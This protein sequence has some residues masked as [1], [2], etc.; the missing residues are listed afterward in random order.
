MTGDS[1]R[2]APAGASAPGR[3]PAWPWRRADKGQLAAVL[4]AG[5]VAGLYGIVAAVA[6]AS[7]LF[8]GPLSGGLAAGAGAALLGT[9]I[10]AALIGWM[11]GLACNMAQMQSMSFV[12]LAMTLGSTA[13]T[14]DAPAATRVATAFMI[15]ALTTAAAGAVLAATGALRAGRIVKFFPLEVLSG[16]VAGTGWLLLTGAMAMMTGLPPG[17]G[18]WLGLAEPSRL[19]QFLPA[20]AF[21]AALVAAMR[22]LRHPFTMLGVIALGIGL[23]Y[24]WLFIAGQ[25][26]ADAIRAGYL[27]R[28]EPGLPGSL[29]SPAMLHDVDWPT[30]AMS[31]PGVLSV[32]VLSLLAGLLNISAL[33]HSAGRTADIDRELKI[34]GLANLLSATA[35]A[36][37]GNTALATSM[38]AAKLGVRQ[39]GAGLVAA[40][41]ALAALFFAEDMIS[42]VPRYVSAGLLLYFG[43]SMLKEWLIDTRRRY[44]RREW[45]VVAA[46]VLMVASHGFLVAII[47]GFLIATVLFAWSY[48]SVPV[49]RSQTTLDRLPSSHER[50]PPEAELL[51]ERGSRVT[52][53]RLQ[54]F[55]FFGTAERLAE[56]VR[57]AVRDAAQ[58]ALAVI[59]DFTAVNRVDTASAIA[60]ARL[61]K[62]VAGRDCRLLLCGM[63]PAL[64]GQLAD[65]GLTIGPGRAAEA[66]A[67]LDAALE[68]MENM[69]LVRFGEESPVRSEALARS[70]AAEDADMAMLLALMSARRYAPGQI[71]IKAGTASDGLGFLADGRVTISMPGDGVP[72]LHVRSAAAGTLLGDIGFA[73][74][75][76]RTA[77]VVAQQP[78]LVYW[79]T[80]EEAAEL[81]V[82]APCHAAAL[83]RILTRSL[84]RKVSSANRLTD[85]LRV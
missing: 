84:A 56:P 63:G 24:L 12:V 33:E 45:W 61:A 54:G 11:S 40:A 42:H 68:E 66:A 36:P 14:L 85:H 52:V 31:L 51:A 18:G 10:T 50:P 6:A 44:A 3:W 49:I 67:T 27:P 17:P 57:R 9:V 81:G 7:L 73:L 2:S 69:L 23:F 47:A 74:G 30:V 38:L 48:A 70:P 59:L 19:L 35:G 37:P 26:V 29:P 1:M 20:V 71:I 60:L 80:A 28:L 64:A 79:I 32:A 21:G 75:S 76:A 62:E 53:L 16:F 8:A 83:N 15:I 46:I 82:R 4:V 65:A 78:C 13:A 55:L 58:P 72:S 43:F 39:R 5:S 77:D 22:I 34:A 25:T 41:A